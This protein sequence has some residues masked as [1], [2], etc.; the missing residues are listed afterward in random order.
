MT[1]NYPLWF[2]ALFIIPAVWAIFIFFYQKKSVSYQLEKFIDPHLLPHLLVTQK[3]HKK[4][5]SFKALLLWSAVWICLTVALAGP[6]WNLREIETFSKDQSLVVLLDLS[7]SMNATD[8]KPSRLG[9]AKQKIEDLIQLSKGVKMGLIAFAADPHMIAPLTDDKETIR[10]L[11]PALGTDLVYVQG[12][13]LASALEMA[14]QMLDVEPGSNKALLIVSDGGFEDQS[15]ISSAKLLAEKG[16]SIH[17]MG[18]G[19]MEGSLLKDA[20][21]N[22]VK[23]SSVPILSKLEKQKLKELSEVGKGYYL[24]GHYSDNDEALILKEL[25]NRA[26]SQEKIGKKN[27][28]WDERFYYFLLPVLPILLFWFRKEACFCFAFSLFFFPLEAKNLSDYLKNSEELAK[29]AFDAGDYESAIHQFKDP[30]RKGVS[31]YKS[32]KFEEAEKMFLTSS[33]TDTSLKS[34]Y[35]LGNSFAL[36]KKLKE[37][38]DAYEKVLQKWPDYAPA[39]DNL[40]IVKSMMENQ[41]SDKPES[42]EKK[43]DDSK[44]DSSPSK[45]GK[46]EENKEENTPSDE[47]NKPD[48]SQK[49]ED[50]PK[51]EK[52]EPSKPEEDVK[53]TPQEKD[54]KEAES[55]EEKGDERDDKAPEA[56]PFKSEEDLDADVW[57]NRISNDPKPFLKNKFY[58]ESKKN[59]TTKGVDPW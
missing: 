7:E 58:I 57:L 45:D 21:G 5:S 42:G 28:I 32:G 23:K 36:Q 6:R 50:S 9:K 52:N 56:E 12:S 8:I 27:K 54:E 41:P 2:F 25:E 53:E 4:K 22:V 43:K 26:S 13:R 39:K 31:Y 30:Y 17:V 20:N 47:E 15:A 18:I 46:K 29:E 49:P 59:G 38:V 19:S 1:F 16:V 3:I 33:Q 11:L 10:H 44:K 35:N 48:E 37:A 24:E 40:E 55:G 51:E 14:S 34:L